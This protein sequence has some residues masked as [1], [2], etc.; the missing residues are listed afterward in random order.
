MLMGTIFSRYNNYYLQHANGTL[1]EEPW[2][3]AVNHMKLMMAL[4]GVQYWWAKNSN[5]YLRGMAE[6]L[7]Q[8]LQEYAN[9]TQENT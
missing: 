5:N 2:N 7:D 3:I 9:S 1:S 6:I 4:P 8:A